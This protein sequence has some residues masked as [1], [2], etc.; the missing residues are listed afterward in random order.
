M[1]KFVDYLIVFAIG[2][3]ICMIGQLLINKTKITSARILVLF[4]LI[5]VVLEAVNVF[6]YI[7]EFAKCGV[8]IPIIGFGSTLIKGAKA[9][10]EIGLL[11][12]VT[13]G[14]N[15]VAAGLSS[16]IVFGF[17]MAIMF[18]SHSKDR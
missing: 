14:M 8:T 5:G 3:F 7:E 16:A 17:L 10:A 18:K 12:A 9:G 4:L 13:Y 15:Y 11:E 2:G 1:D 6:S